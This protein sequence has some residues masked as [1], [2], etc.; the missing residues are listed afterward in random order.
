MATFH[1]FTPPICHGH[2]TSHNI[3]IEVLQYN[4][5]KVR[6]GDIELTPLYKFANTFGEYR[7]S[8]VWSSPENL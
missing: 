2:L 4:K 8:S 5:L 3:F 6:I 7:N 1:Q